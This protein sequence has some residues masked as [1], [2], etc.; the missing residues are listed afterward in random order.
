MADPFIGEI[1]IVGFGFAPNGWA[2]CS[3]QLLAISQNQAL[4]SL[5]GTTYGGDGRTT[6]QLP[7]LRGRA[8]IG[9]GQGPGLTS[10]SWG[11]RGGAEAHTLTSNEMPSHNHVHRSSDNEGDSVSPGG[12]FPATAEEP[13]RPWSSSS[14]G[15][16]MDPAVVANSGGSQAH[17]NMQPYLTLYFVIALVGIF[18]SRS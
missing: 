8:P 18:P 7:D 5:L 15:N 9:F 2:T 13:V 3:G 11:S 12:N 6:F 10:R 16:G 4:F 17:N 1:R 14:S